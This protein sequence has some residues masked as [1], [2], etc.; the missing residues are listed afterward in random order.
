MRTGV[1]IVCVALTVAACK[2]PFA[3]LDGILVENRPALPEEFGRLQV[4]RAGDTL[5]GSPGMG[6]VKGDT[7]M[8]ARDGVAVVTLEA[9]WQI[10]FE[11]GTVAK[12]ENPSIFVKI[13][14]LIIKKVK[15]VT[16]PLTVNNEFVSAGVEGTEFVFEVTSDNTVRIS[17]LE[18]RVVVHSR[19]AGWA[20]TAYEAGEAGMIAARAAP[21]LRRRLDPAEVR[22]IRDRVQN[23]ERFVRP[24]GVRSVRGL[25][26]TRTMSRCT[27]PNLTDRTE[28]V[29]REMLKRASLQTRTVKRRRYGDLVT[30]QSPAAGTVVTCG[31]PVDLEIGTDIGE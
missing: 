24:A 19:Q 14:K 13:G 20:A 26:E 10:I 31:S 23:I 6:I 30:G 27:V 7:I 3:R 4:I 5:A 2:P 17:V 16:E 21:S 29:A 28:Q 8:T 1:G 18:G 9:G 12:I 11:P 15:E 25:T 22:A